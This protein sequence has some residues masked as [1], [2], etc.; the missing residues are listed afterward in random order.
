MRL[1]FFFFWQWFVILNLWLFFLPKHCV[2]DPDLVIHHISLLTF[3]SMAPYNAVFWSLFV[4]LICSDLSWRKKSLLTSLILIITGKAHLYSSRCLNC[5]SLLHGF[6][7][8]SQ[9]LLPRFG[10]ETISHLWLYPQPHWQ[11]RNFTWSF[12]K[13]T[14]VFKIVPLFYLPLAW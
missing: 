2:S 11:Q 4:Y 1:F 10:W 9:T 14:A 7:N 12:P 5:R 13:I 3:C 8:P 6:R